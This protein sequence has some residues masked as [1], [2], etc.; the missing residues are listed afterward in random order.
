MTDMGG[1]EWQKTAT[2]LMEMLKAGDLTVREVLLLI[3]YNAPGGVEVVKALADTLFG[4]AF[5]YKENASIG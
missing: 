4:D 5:R 3:L 1:D 2:G